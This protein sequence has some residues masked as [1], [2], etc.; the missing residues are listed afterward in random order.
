MNDQPTI[1]KEIYD[2]KKIRVEESKIGFEYGEFVERSKRFR[3][4]ETPNRFLKA[5]SD[6]TETN[7]IVEIKRASPSNKTIND[8]FDIADLA[9]SCEAFGATAIAVL[10]EEDHFKGKI[11]DLI[12]ARNLTDLPVLRKD[13]IFDEFQI[14]ESALIGA[15]AVLLIAAMLGDSD[16]E[17]LY[18]L[19]C[20]LGLD[21]LVE[22]SNLAELKRAA[23]L[24]AKMIGITNRNPNTFEVSLDV[25][26]EL[27]SHGP[28]EA[29]MICEGGLS[30]V[31]ELNEMKELG[32]SGFLVGESLMNSNELQ[33]NLLAG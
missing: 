28:K 7:I 18:S 14:Y 19:S 4:D 26:R 20:D 31:K 25:S 15:D 9:R 24:G 30:S 33:L 32:F 12:T 11:E 2:Q 17:R 8:S 27:I 13:F 1:L 22:T 10:T 21:V 29:L 3:K 16:L 6:R 5:F 23:E